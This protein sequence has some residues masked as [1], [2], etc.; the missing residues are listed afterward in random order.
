MEVLAARES[1]DEILLP[2]FQALD[3]PSSDRL[4]AALIADHAKPIASSVIRYRLRVFS[5]SG[6]RPSD[7][8][9]DVYSDVLIKLITR[10]RTFKTNPEGNGI[11]NFHAYVRVIASNSCSAYLRKKSPQ[12]SRLD[13]KLRYFLTHRVGFA[14]WKSREDD[15]LCGIQLWQV[16][17]KPYIRTARVQQ[18]CD[19]PK[20]FAQV[21]NGGA[22]AQRMLLPDLLP[23]ILEWVG[24]PVELDDLI[25]IVADL[26]GIKDKLDRFDSDSPNGNDARE[27]RDPRLAIDVEL[28]QRYRLQQLWAEICELPLRQRFALLMNLRDAQGRELTGLLPLTGVCTFRQIAAALELSAESLAMLCRDLPMDDATIAQRLAITRQQ[29]INLRK[30]ARER[31]ARRMRDFD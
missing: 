30:S 28:G 3:E 20:A 26:Q 4:L 21:M 17:D 29:V 13:D 23:A 12:R 1:S 6:S 24:G 2:F 9:E 22:D 10:L 31:L 7:D 27:I 18:L 15:W 19:S 11:G 14:L 25:F 5:T 8:A 16:E